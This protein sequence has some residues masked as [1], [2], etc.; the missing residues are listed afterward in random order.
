MYEASPHPPPCFSSWLCFLWPNAVN[1]AWLLVRSWMHL[2]VPPVMC[3][4]APWL[5]GATALGTSLP[6]SLRTLLISQAW[7]AFVTGGALCQTSTALHNQ[8]LCFYFIFFTLNGLLWYEHFLGLYLWKNIC[9]ECFLFLFFTDNE[10]TKPEN[11][12]TT[13]WIKIT[14]KGNIS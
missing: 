11:I 5:Q 12:K 10:A 4:C 2:D 13:V 8:F 9:F 14:K 3:G 7:K 1:P 6:E